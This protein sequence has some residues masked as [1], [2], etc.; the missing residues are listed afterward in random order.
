MPVSKVVLKEISGRDSVQNPGATIEWD[1]HT[2]SHNDG[3]MIVKQWEGFPRIGDQYTFRSGNHLEASDYVFCNEIEAKC[4]SK[5]PHGTVWR[6]VATYGPPDYRSNT[7]PANQNGPEPSVEDK[8]TLSS[9]IEYIQEVFTAD[10]DGKPVRNSANDP[11]SEVPTIQRAI[12]T[13]TITRIEYRNPFA[14]KRGYKD[15]VNADTWCGF[16]PRTLLLQIGVN[17]TGQFTVTYTMRYK[18]EGWNLDILDAGYY[19]K[20]EASSGGEGTGNPPRERI[21]VGEDS[22]PAEV[23]Q[24]LDGQGK[25]LAEDQDDVFIS[26]RQYESR[27]FSLLNLPPIE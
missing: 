13:Y 20:E 17:W 6:V 7:S 19:E 12:D 2:D 5:S 24:R 22:E 16:P 26:F 23:P 1:A 9:A 18:P 3:P 4:V 14:K 11:F 15:V 27:Y 10:K 8:F 21:K 25:V